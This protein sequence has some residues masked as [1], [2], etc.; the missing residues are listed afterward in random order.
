M[1][2]G[3]SGTGAGEGAGAAPPGS[4]AFHWEPSPETF[5][6]EEVGTP[7]PSGTGEHLQFTLEKRGISTWEALDRL[8]RALSLP[9]AAFGTA[10]LKDARAHT[11]QGVTVL[12]LG[13]DGV[14]RLAALDLPDMVLGPALATERKLR[15]GQARG[16]RFELRLGFARLAL[17]EETHR[18]LAR[19]LAQVAEDGLANSFGPQRFGLDGRAGELGRLLLEADP[20]AYLLAHGETEL[21]LR[22]ARDA[23]LSEAQ[24]AAGEELLA[25]LASNSKAAQRRLA[26][27]AGLLPSTLCPLARQLARRRGDPQAALRA[28]PRRVRRMHLCAHQALLFERLLELRGESFREL[29]PGD[30]PV[31]CGRVGSGAERRLPSGP[32]F[33]RR[34]PWPDAT[35]QAGAWELLVL[36]EAGLTG[37]ELA[38]SSLDGA[39]RP[40][41][42][43]PEGAS[44]GPLEATKAVEAVEAPAGG[45]GAEALLCFTLP[46]G[47]YATILLRVLR[48]E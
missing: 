46:A 39:R 18:R 33:G 21:R 37:V 32:L 34:S 6:V 4:S 24:M 30:L 3:R 42:V 25:A 10:G 41:C 43:F 44:L 12:G 7:P 26:R 29:L 20:R 11:V 35:S 16:N 47:A 38:R 8:G 2:S 1:N 23:Q 40:L 19:R 22:A 31:A 9:G 14:Q 27:S 48:Q 17:A 15:A 36:E 5:R 28:I 13:A 45:E